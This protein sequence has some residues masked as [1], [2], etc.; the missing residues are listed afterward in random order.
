MKEKIVFAVVVK[1]RHFL[2]DTFQGFRN[3][4]GMNLVAYEKMIQEAI[5]EV[6]H[7]LISENPD[8]YDI[9]FTTSQVTNGACEI[10]AYGKVKI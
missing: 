2:S 3:M 5:E 9:K 6:L 4:I 10:I 7:K 8:V 1:S